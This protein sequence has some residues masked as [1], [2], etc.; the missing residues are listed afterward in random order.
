MEKS[1]YKKLNLK[2]LESKKTVFT[3]TEVALKD[4]TLIE[5]NKEIDSGKKKVTLISK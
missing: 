3:S 4:V 5:W 2:V 1:S